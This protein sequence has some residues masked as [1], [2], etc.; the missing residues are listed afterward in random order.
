MKNLTLLGCLT[1]AACNPPETTL[2]I[3]ASDT[4]QLLRIKEV[5]WPKAYHTGD[6]NLL[7]SL[8]L[9]EFEMID[10]SGGWYTKMDELDYLKTKPAAPDSFHYEIKRLDIFENGTAI[11][12]GTGHIFNDSSETVY[13]SSNVL[14]KYEGRWRAINSHVSGVKE[15]KSI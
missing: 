10:A 5:L 13:Q 4:S 8:L 6:V 3:N 15:F 12:S 2:S 9:D 7:D 14:I 1:L 11:I